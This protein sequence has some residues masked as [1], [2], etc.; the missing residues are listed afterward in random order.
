MITGEGRHH[1]A[2]VLV[3][4][5]IVGSCGYADKLMVGSKASSK[6]FEFD[7]VYGHVGSYNIILN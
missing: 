6:V 3:S 5:S 2:S 1:N 4:S 7:R